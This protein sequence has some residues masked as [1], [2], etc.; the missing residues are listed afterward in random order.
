V[1]RIAFVDVTKT[2]AD[3]KSAAVDHVSFTV[4]EGTICML[5]GT[6]G[7]G[8]TTLLR[9][10][11]RLI[12]PT[13]GEVEVDGVATTAQ[14]PIALRRRMGYV[15]QQVGLFPH[16]TIEDNVRIVPS[17]LGKSAAETSGRVDELLRLV[18]LEPAEY[19]KRY[20][21]QLSGG[22]QQRVGLAR[23]LAAD[24]SVLLMD[25]PFGALDAITRDR[26]QEELLRIQRGVRKTILFV[27]HDV[28]EALKLGDQI[29]V[30]S[31]GKLIQQGT[32]I[33]LLASPANDFVRRLLGADSV[34][35]QFEYLPV[36][37]A[38]EPAT[39][40]AQARIPTD[41]T[42]LQALLGLIQKGEQAVL[43]EDQG[44]VRGQV[45]VSSIFRAAQSKSQETSPDSD[46]RAVDSAAAR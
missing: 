21:R 35:R 22:Q 39:D 32:A 13:S 40:D 15:I 27:T 28:Q 26:L 7:S 16:L 36:T 34:L 20:P 42:L 37:M 23:A 1:A 8:K 19:R 25:E 9:M 11:N 3:A 4:N 38:L 5:L 18:G 33:D 31:E 29:V 44:Q 24:P 41:A 12:D 45:S 2:Y 30:L 14:D 6:S 43:V 46:S 10:V 17:I